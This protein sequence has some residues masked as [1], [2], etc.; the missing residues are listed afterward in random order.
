MV[1]AVVGGLAA[2]AYY[3][4]LMSVRSVDVSGTTAVSADEVRRVAQVPSGKPLLQVDT[5]AIANR[6]SVLPAVESVNV[7]RSYP[8][9]IDIA[10]VERT[11]VVTV[12]REDKKIGVMD[13]LGMVYA[14]FEPKALPK[15]FSSLPRLETANPSAKDAPTRAVLRVVQDLPSWLRANVRAVQ[16]DSP[17]DVTLLLRS[18]RKAVWGDSGRSADKAEALRHLLTISGD[19]YNVSSPEFASVK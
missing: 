6:V 13:R 5:A 1:I 15:E 11:P 12:E 16:A 17:S 10:V 19:E 18:G 14:T 3:T 8:S 7:S 9:T 2:V 4:P